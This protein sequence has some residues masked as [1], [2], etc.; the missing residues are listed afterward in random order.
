MSKNLETNAIRS[1]YNEALNGLKSNIWK[2]FGYEHPVLVEGGGYPGVWLECAP[3]EGLIYGRFDAETARANHDVFF[4]HQ[5]EDGYLPCWVWKEKAGTGQIQM[6]VPIAA[7]ALETAELLGDEGF[8]AKA[9]SACS[10]WDAWL[11]RHRNTRGTG[12]C[13]A[14]CEYDTGHDNSPRFAGL[15]HDCPNEDAKVCPDAG[16][17]P[18]LA[19]DLSATVFGGRQALS[20]MAARLGKN[21]EAQMW[22]DR[23]EETRRLIL[24]HC[25]DAEDECFYDVDRDGHFVKIRGDVMIRVLGEHVVDQKMFDRIF[26]RHII[27]PEGF[28]PPYPLPSI[29]VSDPLFNH[30]MPPN[31]WGGPS[32]ALTALRAPRWMLHYGKEEALNHLMERWL[33]ALL[34]APGFMQQLNPWT[35]EF[36]G[37]NGYSPAMCVFID[38][39]DRLKLLK[40]NSEELTTT[41]KVG[42]LR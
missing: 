41:E 40:P 7:T 25:Y 21:D 26:E 38:F 19:P 13:E 11:A 16:K 23:A 4:H 31:C 15:P 2:V 18:Y 27:N 34:A 1:R 36:S 37:A 28:W 6:V 9:Y 30:A 8:L 42:P 14:F 24:K 12:L 5:H 29:A 10:R 33:E 20:L 22:T 35:G 39:V 32:Q 17:L 3:L